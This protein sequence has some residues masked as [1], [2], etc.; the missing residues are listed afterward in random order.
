M[1]VAYLQ[2]RYVWQH[3]F[4][5]VPMVIFCTNNAIGIAR[6]PACLSLFCGLLQCRI[7]MLLKNKLKLADKI[8]TFH[9]FQIA[10]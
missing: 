5:R 8:L 9:V 6:K 7:K 10:T 2:S 1:I 3:L 4:H